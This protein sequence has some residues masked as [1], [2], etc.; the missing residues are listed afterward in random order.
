MLVK[1]IKCPNCKDII[2]SRTR[3]DFHYCS[4]RACAIDGGTDYVKVLYNPTQPYTDIVSV[5]I[6]ATQK[7]LYDDWNLHQDKFGRIKSNKKE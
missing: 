5:E 4:C 3:H 7:E 2:Y 6:E 1:G